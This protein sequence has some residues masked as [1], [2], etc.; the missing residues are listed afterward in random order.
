MGDD[1]KIDITELDKYNLLGYDR[2]LRS[3]IMNFIDK[4]YPLSSNDMAEVLEGKETL[5]TRERK[6]VRGL[7]LEIKDEIIDRELKLRK[8]DLKKSY[9]NDTMNYEI[10]K[11]LEVKKEMLDM[12]KERYVEKKNRKL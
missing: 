2:E 8:E 4:L 7:L 5:K 9:L 6:Y 10:K 3:F 12:V 11:S 1:M